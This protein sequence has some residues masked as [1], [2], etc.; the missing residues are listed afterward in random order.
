MAEVQ[1]LNFFVD[2]LQFACIIAIL[3]IINYRS[4][5]EAGGVNKIFEQ[6][7]PAVGKNVFRAPN[8]QH[9][10]HSCIVLEIAVRF[11]MV[12]DPFLLQVMGIG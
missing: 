2:S 8:Q 4:K 1:L 5:V 12:F 3:Y 6:V 9:E 11:L 7:R 10:D